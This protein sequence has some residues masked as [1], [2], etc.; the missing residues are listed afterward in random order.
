MIQLNIFI[1][2]LKIPPGFTDRSRKKRQ[3][4]EIWLSVAVI[5]VCGDQSGP[6]ALINQSLELLLSSTSTLYVS[7]WLEPPRSSC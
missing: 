1:N 7:M 2:K 6:V 5:D 4:G 3:D